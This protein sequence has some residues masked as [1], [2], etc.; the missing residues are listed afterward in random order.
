MPETYYLQCRYGDAFADYVIT[1]GC[2]DDAVA[3]A[4]AEFAFE[5]GFGPGRASWIRVVG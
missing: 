3:E 5:L 2:W 4:R 1:A